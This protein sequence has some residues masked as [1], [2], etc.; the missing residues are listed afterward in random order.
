VPL[1]FV[2]FLGQTTILN[3]FAH[4]HTPLVFTLLRTTNGLLLGLIVGSAL[5]GVVRRW[6]KERTSDTVSS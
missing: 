4:L 6:T 5:W 2:A 1:A 3:S